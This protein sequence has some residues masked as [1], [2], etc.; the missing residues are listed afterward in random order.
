MLH[1]TWGSVVVM[2]LLLAGSGVGG[3]QNEVT[4]LL[5]RTAGYIRTNEESFS[6]LVCEE[7][8]SQRARGDHGWETRDL[9][10]E[11]ALV[12]VGDG[13]WL[14]FRDVHTVD[15]LRVPGRTGQL[16]DRSATRTSIRG[17]VRS[18]WH[19]RARGTTSARFR[20][21][22]IRRPSRCTCCAGRTT[23]DPPS[24]SRDGSGSRIGMRQDWRST[25]DR[26]R[27]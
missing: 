1:V 8:Y 25:N 27:G 2:C 22:S 6:R 17:N 5:T 11:V 16:A 20:G 26:S 19:R 10:S 12:S 23:H 15:G 7:R 9:R 24:A 3:R 14:F 13:E 18:E 4:D 21:P